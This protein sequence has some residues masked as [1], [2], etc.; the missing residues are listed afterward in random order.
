MR[1]CGSNSDPNCLATVPRW[2]PSTPPLTG[3][4]YSYNYMGHQWTRTR[5]LVQF[6]SFWRLVVNSIISPHFRFPFEENTSHTQTL[7]YTRSFK[8]G[9]RASTWDA[10]S[11]LWP[12]RLPHN[13]WNSGCVNISL[14]NQRSRQANSAQL[15]TPTCRA[16]VPHRET[17]IFHLAAHRRIQKE[18][19]RGRLHSETIKQGN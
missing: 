6:R 4:M 9:P 13:C 11:R 2:K 12:A 14:L 17:P 1:V 19:V 7:S 16:F 5:R 3:Y 15:P 10:P 18:T 8:T